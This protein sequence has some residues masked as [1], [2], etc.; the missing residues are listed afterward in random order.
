VD[1]YSYT[2]GESDV[3]CA[4]AFIEMNEEEKRDRVQDL[5]KRTLAKAKGAVK[6]IEIFGDLNRRIYLY[7]SDKKHDYLIE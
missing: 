4:E 2:S 5:W 1:P 3:D 7:G 6:V